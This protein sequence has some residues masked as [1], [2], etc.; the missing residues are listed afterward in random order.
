MPEMPIYL[1]HHS[2]TPCDPRV[3]EAMLPYFGGDFGNPAA[4]VH[5]HG[6]R[7]AKALEEARATVAGLMRCRPSELSFTSGATESNNIALRGVATTPGQHV[8]TTE[9]EHSSVLFTLEALAGQGIELTVL[10]PDRHGFVSPAQVRDALRETTVLVS[11]MAANAE[12]GTLEPVAEIGEVCRR[13]GVLFH[14]DATQAVGK[15]PFDFETVPCDL[16]SMSAHKFYGPKGVGALYVREGTSVFPTSTGG[17]QEH[18][19]RSGTVDV[20]GVVGLAVALSLAMEKREE[21]SARLLEMRNRLWD[22]IVR[23][24]PGAVVNG[25]REARLPGNLHVSFEGIDIEALLHAMRRFSLSTGSAC[26]SGKKEPSRALRAIGLDPKLALSSLRFGLGR[27]NDPSQIDL[28]V[29]DLR[30]AISRL[31]EISV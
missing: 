31:R 10:R 3:I 29:D 15:V 28:L 25:P 4:I 30:V 19:L 18:K 8:V 22:R 27:S 24:I 6:R 11:V 23:E 26:A 14:T 20:A 7:A 12:F 9:V 13:A 2:T 21:E 17:G 1:D 5:E 16:A